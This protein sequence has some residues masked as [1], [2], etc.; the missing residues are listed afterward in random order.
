MYNIDLPKLREISL[1]NQALQGKYKSDSVTLS[2]KGRIML[3]LFP[4]HLD[5]PSL[6]TIQS[7]GCSFVYP[8]FVTISSVN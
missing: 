5:L 4:Y 1:G 6:T 7:D 2:M 8:R 3:L